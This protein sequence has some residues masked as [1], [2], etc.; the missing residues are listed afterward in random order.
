MISEKKKSK[1]LIVSIVVASVILVLVILALAVLGYVYFRLNSIKRIPTV[2]T[3]SV[4]ENF[5]RDS[6]GD[7][8]VEVLKPE[9]VTWS[10]EESGADSD[11]WLLSN[12]NCINILLIGIDGRGYSGRSDT[13]I[14]CTYDREKKTATMTSFLRDLYVQIPGYSDN[15]LNAAYAFGGIELLDAA[16]ETNFG[17]RVDGHVMVDFDTFPQVID[18]LGGVD[19]TLTQAESDYLSLSGAGEYHMDG[20]LAMLYARIRYIDSDFG[21]TNRQRTLLNSLFERFK[22]LS[23]GEIAGA[24][25]QVLDLVYT[26]MDAGTILSY[27]SEVMGLQEIRQMHVP[28][29]GEYNDAYINEMMVLVPDLEQ[30]HDRLGRELFG[31]E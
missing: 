18:A 29:D 16:M 7:N 14:L 20:E 21:R 25:N 13:M 3:S 10:R 1:A 9:D 27:G 24:A 5:E 22:K 6:I 31:R 11:E 19:I 23:W 26:D 8:S 28:E 17:I 12:P 15:R 4:E 2:Q 30:I